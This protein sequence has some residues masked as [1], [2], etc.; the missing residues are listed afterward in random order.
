MAVK[1][2]KGQILKDLELNPVRNEEPLKDPKIKT[3][4][5]RSVF[6]EYESG[7]SVEDGGKRKGESVVRLEARRSVKRMLQEFKQKTLTD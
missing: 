5:V 4:M 3:N 2:N 6:L 7:S 1:K